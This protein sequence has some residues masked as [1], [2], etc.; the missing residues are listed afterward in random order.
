MVPSPGTDRYADADPDRHRIAPRIHL[1]RKD[2]EDTVRQESRGF[3]LRR[4]ALDDG[5]TRRRPVAR[6]CRPLRRRPED[7][8]T[9]LRIRSPSPWPKMSFTALKRSRSRHRTASA[10][11]GG[12]RRPGPVSGGGQRSSIGKIRQRIVVSEVFYRPFGILARRQIP[13]EDHIALPALVFDRSADP[14][15]G[16]VSAVRVKE[17]SL[18]CPLS[19]AKSCGLRLPGASANSSRRCLPMSSAGFRPQRVTNRSLT[20][21]TRRR[22]GSPC[23]P[24]RHWRA[25]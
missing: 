9:F 6:S 3:R 18:A 19:G 5:G 1:F 7:I 20:S 16:H 22:E 13:H 14:F 25:P 4:S 15:D 10:H 17:L 11:C 21:M 2:L 23:P 8:A 12:R 24:A